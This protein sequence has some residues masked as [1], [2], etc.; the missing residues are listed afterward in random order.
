MGNKRA[1]RR[2]LVKL[3]ASEWLGSANNII[4]A[5]SN[6]YWV[7]PEAPHFTVDQLDF[8]GTAAD[9][10]V[11]EA[12][13]EAMDA[14]TRQSFVIW[15]MSREVYRMTMK[16]NRMLA[17]L[18]AAQAVTLTGLAV[19]IAKLDQVFGTRHLTDIVIDYAQPDLYPR[20]RLTDRKRME[21]GTLSVV[22]P[23]FVDLWESR[24]ACP[25]SDGCVP[26]LSVGIAHIGEIL[27]TLYATYSLRARLRGPQSM[28][29]WF[30]RVLPPRCQ[31]PF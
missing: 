19:E 1:R 16:T 6:Y 14:L 28:P 3:E 21:W 9:L 10:A 24:G 15:C 22:V 25:P 11:I 4:W 26:R 7:S 20:V 29:T 13:S 31:C 30:G 5:W 8:A 2:P 12:A 17:S 27:Q 23:A 18:C